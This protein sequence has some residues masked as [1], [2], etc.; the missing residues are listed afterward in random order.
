MLLNHKLNSII[1]CGF[2]LQGGLCI[3]FYFLIV[4]M[5]DFFASTKSYGGNQIWIH[6]FSQ[7][8]L[9]RQGINIYLILV[10]SLFNLTVNLKR[11]VFT[12][13]TVRQNN[14]WLSF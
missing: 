10:L 14:E 7:F 3:W 12:F 11:K 9:S 4:L 13:F 8:I 2:F 6:L 5:K 1:V